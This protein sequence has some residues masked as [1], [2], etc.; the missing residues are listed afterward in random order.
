MG[1]VDKSVNEIGLCR[2]QSVA[3]IE[4][5][6]LEGQA[7]SIN[8]NTV[9][10]SRV[11][12]GSLACATPVRR[13]RNALRHA[14]PLTLGLGL[15]NQECKGSGE[16][17]PNALSTNHNLPTHSMTFRCPLLFLRIHSCCT[18]AAGSCDFQL[19]LWKPSHHSC[20]RDFRAC[21]RLKSEKSTSK[22]QTW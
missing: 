5:I 17:S 18:F 4:V 20:V 22:G 19:L 12:Q 14:R 8:K 1:S 21:L 10:N 13:G 7:P 2:R 3:S 15:V 6:L 9:F 16:P 11:N